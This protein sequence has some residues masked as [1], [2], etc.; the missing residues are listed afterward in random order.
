M[1]SELTALIF[2]SIIVE[3][4]IIDERFNVDALLSIGGSSPREVSTT[5]CIAL[6]LA[7]LTKKTM[8]KYFIHANGVKYT[9]MQFMFALYKKYKGEEGMKS[10]TKEIQSSIDKSVISPI[11]RNYNR[12]AELPKKGM[13]EDKLISLL[14]EWA[15]HEQ[16]RWNGQHKYES[17]Q[18]YHGEPSLSSLQ[19]KAYSLFSVSNPLHPNTFPFVRKMESEII[20]MTLPLFHGHVDKGQCGMVA[21]GGTESIILAVRAYK[22]YARAHKHINYPELVIPET[23]H[24]AFDKACDLMDIKLIKVAVDK[25]SYRADWREMEKH[26][27][28]QT[29]AIVGSTPQFAQ[30]VM[31]DI[32]ALSALALKYDIGLHVDC[33]LGSFLLPMLA[34]LGYQVKPFDF[35]L[36]GVTSISCDTHKYGFANKGTSVLMFKDAAYRRH[37]Y[38]CY[39]ECVIGMYGTATCLGS[40]SGGLVVATWSTMMYFGKQGYLENMKKIMDAVEKVKSGI[41]EMEEIEI[42]GEPATSVVALKAKRKYESKVDIFKVQDA[43]SE[44]GWAFNQCQNPNCIHFCFTVAN[45]KEPE[46]F[47]AE[48]K[49]SVKEVVKHPEK[50]KSTSAA[51]YGAVL[52][53]PSEGFKNEVLA[54]Y[55]DATYGVH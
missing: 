47:V 51:M 29:I 42:M 35:R 23:A 14:T 32:E 13:D 41:L 31:D 24:A 43:M 37:A 30:G 22:N 25:E 4:L 27:T 18:I 38:F 49:E 54:M 9:I 44:R 5:L 33:C 48:L 40:R 50:F 53:I 11:I 36:K 7:Y 1:L 52:Q 10:I 45:C 15:E 20:A 17:G 3:Y 19:N 26:I 28:S 55:L 2:V 21:S 39:S 46:R 8:Q 6:L 16:S 34:E 12:N